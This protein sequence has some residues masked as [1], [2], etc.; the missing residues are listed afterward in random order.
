MKF[1]QKKLVQYQSISG[2]L[3]PITIRGFRGVNT[4]DPFSIDDSFFT[5][6]SNLTTDDY[7]AVSTRPGYSVLGTVGTKVL[8]L[9]VWKGIE[10]HA[11][12]NDGT[13]RKWTGSSWATLASGLSTSAPWTFTNFQGNLDDVN[14]IG[15]NGVNPVKRYDGSTVQDLTGAPSAGKYITTYQ[16]RLWVAVGKEL[17]S[18]SVDN[19]TDWNTF[20]QEDGSSYRKTMESTAGEDIN[21]L[22]GGLT[23]LTIGMPNSLHE[24][25]GGVPSNFNTRLITED[26]GIVSNAAAVTN[27][28][29]MHFIHNTGIYEYAGGVLPN[30]DFSDTVKTYLD[31]INTNSA[32]GSDG[33][34]LYFYI[35]SDTLLV[36][37]PRPGITAWSVWK[38]I[39]PT[40][41]ALMNHELYIG[42]DQGRILKLGGTNDGGNFISWYCVTKPFS[43]G[44]LAQKLRWYKLFI[45]ADVPSGSTLQV[46]LSRSIDGDD[47]EEVTPYMQGSRVIIP[48]SRFA[49]ENYLRI[50]IS[51]TGPVTIREITRQQRQ[52]PL[53]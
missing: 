45:V 9:G 46:F 41:F 19:P 47:W 11:V 20:D 18:C 34:K 48:V 51:G 35:P 2:M 53:Y 4:F 50:K 15:C 3:Q 43:N 42:D 33:E 7:P 17:W 44:S 25:Y 26:E 13:W 52:L 36:Y 40:C 23:K 1:I 27:S 29:V 39:H 12:F 49:N 16:N 10:L 32:A 8:G 37:D 31:G 5:N 38:G 22:S 21:M 24:L 28:G 14:L 30:K 6:M